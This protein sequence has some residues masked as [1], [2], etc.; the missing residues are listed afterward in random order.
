MSTIAKATTAIGRVQAHESQGLATLAHTD[1]QSILAYVQTLPRIDDQAQLAAVAQLEVDTIRPRLKAV[2][3][4]R[5][6]GAK[7]LRALAA[8]IAKRWK[9]AIDILTQSREI[10]RAL[11]SDYQTRIAAEAQAALPAATTPAEVQAATSAVVAPPPDSVSGRQNWVAIVTDITIVPGEYFLLD[12]ARLA[13][14][15]KAMKSGLSIPGIR[16]ENKPTVVFR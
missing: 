5:D 16:A 1:A 7:P 8:T 6:L 2:T 12:T 14:E 13:R 3:E 10:A 9:P 15:A 4:E 11:I